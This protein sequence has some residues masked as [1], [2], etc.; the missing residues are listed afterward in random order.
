MAELEEAVK[1]GL[2]TQDSVSG[3]FSLHNTLRERVRGPQ[4]EMAKS[5]LLRFVAGV[6]REAGE[7]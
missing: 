7:L 3:R 6:L 2:V 4:R 1:A 5:R